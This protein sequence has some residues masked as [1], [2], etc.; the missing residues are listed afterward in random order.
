MTGIPVIP[1]VLFV[2][3]S[4]AEGSVNSF[5]RFL[6]S[7]CSVEM[8]EK[9]PFGRNDNSCLSTPSHL[10]V[11]APVGHAA[12]LCSAGTSTASVP[13]QET[14]LTLRCGPVAGHG[15]AP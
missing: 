7:L 13:M 6:H 12:A 1:G 4:G 8:T 2:I 5:Y 3:P 11:T 14:S 10:A 15:P 9:V